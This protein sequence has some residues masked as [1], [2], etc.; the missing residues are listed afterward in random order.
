MSEI[1]LDNV[2]RY[3]KFVLNK[4]Y[5]VFITSPGAS[6]DAGNDPSN[7]QIDVMILAMAP[8]SQSM[9]YFDGLQ[10]FGPAP[11]QDVVEQT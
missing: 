4:R 6:Y 7:N 10:R 9:P 8:V 2:T 3:A 1:V 11:V 5:P